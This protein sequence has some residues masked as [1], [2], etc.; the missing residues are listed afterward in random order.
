MTQ[1]SRQTEILRPAC[2]DLLRIEHTS[3][4]PELIRRA[5]PIATSG[6]PGPVVVDVPED[7]CHGTLPFQEERV[8]GRRALR[9]GARRSAAGR[10]PTIPRA[11]RRCLPRP[12][13]R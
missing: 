7:V 13:G 12:S 8:R 2:K 10:P 3:R 11:P 5:F 1:E 4:I 9:G 6:R